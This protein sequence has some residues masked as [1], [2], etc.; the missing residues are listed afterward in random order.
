[1]SDG[2]YLVAFLSIGVFAVLAMM[3]TGWLVVALTGSHSAQVVTMLVSFIPW[4]L[5][6]TRLALKVMP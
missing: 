1:M 3:A 6:G 5:V 2:W 4:C